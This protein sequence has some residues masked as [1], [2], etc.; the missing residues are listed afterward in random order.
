MLRSFYDPFRSRLSMRG[1]F[2][3]LY[4]F[5]E[6]IAGAATSEDY[7]F[8]QQNFNVATNDDGSITLTSLVNNR[9]FSVGHF[10]TPS[11]GDLRESVRVDN[12]Q[13]GCTTYE[14]MVISDI[15]KMHS[16]HPS[17]TFQ[18]ASQFNCLEF[19]SPDI[20]PECGITGYA[21]DSTQGPA[22]ALAC[23]SGTVYRNYFAV[24]ETNP[25]GTVGQSRGS[26]INNLDD[27]ERLL[28]NA[29]HHYW[30]VENGYTFSDSE[31]LDRL[32][33]ELH[34]RRVAGPDADEGIDQLMASIKVGLHAN[35]GVDFAS[36]FIEV[37]SPPVS[38]T[39]VYCS[40][41]SC[42]YSGIVNEKWASLAQLVLDANYE[43][44]LW[45]AVLNRGENASDESRNV[46][47]TLL[48]GGVFGNDKEW[49]GTAIGRAI[50]RAT[51]RRADINI[52][53]CHYR[54]VNLEFVAI[55]DRALQEELDRLG[56]NG[57]VSSPDS[58]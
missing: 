12:L 4:G 54:K 32:E 43:A 49:I 13:V 20:T 21:Y 42:A 38:V 56:M 31:S 47:L 58:R 9:S 3:Q 25:V 55:V 5:E 8:N 28:E 37:A 52:V 6:R 51:T 41:I 19:P 10:S 29:K 36:R 1:W 15:F 23:A 18:A 39:Q 16:E 30:K 46:F 48:G 24:P 45:A 2:K 17:A 14:H 53:I 26:Q 50:A 7:V 35:V 44:T 22:C 40:A 11:L 57:S 33:L 34:R 27:L